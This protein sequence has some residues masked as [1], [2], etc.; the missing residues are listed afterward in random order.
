MAFSAPSSTANIFRRVAIERDAV[1]GHAV[2]DR[3]DHITRLGRD[4]GLRAEFGDNLV[5]NKQRPF[6]QDFKPWEI[7]HAGPAFVGPALADQNLAVLFDDDARFADGG[8]LL[9]GGE[10]GDLIL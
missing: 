4:A 2:L 8:D 5:A 3:R 1:T 10:F 7:P 9:F 6:A